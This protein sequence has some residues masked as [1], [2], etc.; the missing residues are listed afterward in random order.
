[1][2]SLS[3]SADIGRYLAALFTKQSYILIFRRTRMCINETKN[4]IWM[5]FFQAADFADLR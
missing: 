2:Y 3:L 4:F 1:M 5:K